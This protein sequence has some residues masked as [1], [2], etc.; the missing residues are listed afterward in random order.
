MDQT[1]RFALPFLAPGQIHKEM[2]VNECLQR[3]DFLL[4]GMAHGAAGNDPPADPVAGQCYLVGDAPTGEWAGNSGTIAGFT[5]GGWRFVTPPEG[6]QMLVHTTGE[7]IVRRNG[8]WEAGIVRAREVRVGDQPVLRSR[9]PPIDA[10]EGG[11][12]VDVEARSAIAE[13]IAALRAH[14]LIE[15]QI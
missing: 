9:Q 3:I 1:P 7:T 2:Q 10:P 4:N 6:A 12:T 8:A 11:S 5:E 15:S 13:V 14:G